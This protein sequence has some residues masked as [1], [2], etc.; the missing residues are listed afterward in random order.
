MRCA[1]AGLMLVVSVMAVGQ[2]VGARGGFGGRGAGPGFRGGF[3]GPGSG[4]GFQSGFQGVPRL[5]TRPGST[6]GLPLLGP[7]SP[8]GG[9]NPG[10]RPGFGGGFPISRGGAFP[11]LWGG[12][13]G[14]PGSY[15]PVTNIVMMP[16]QQAPAALGPAQAPPPARPEVKEYKESQDTSAAT[17]SEVKYFVLAM[18]DGTR[19]SASLVW[20][21]DGDLH[22]V[23]AEGTHVRVPAG[24]VDREATRQLNLAQ[25]LNLRLQ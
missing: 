25:N 7:I 14:F 2:G 11:I 10:F 3:R 24:Q 18:K 12:Y 8:L 15:T 6:A 16:A 22:Y 13:G 21:Q 9:V 5:P 23:T 19:P 1:P 17:P 4:A 20:M